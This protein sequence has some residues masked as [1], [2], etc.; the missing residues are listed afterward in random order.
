MIDMSPAF[1]SGFCTDITVRRYELIAESHGRYNYEAKE[2]KMRAS[3]QPAGPEILER[4]EATAQGRMFKAVTIFSLQALQIG[5]RPDTVL[6]NGDEYGITD[7]E[8][9]LASNA[10]KATAVRFLN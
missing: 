10:F 3:V 2:F 4:I 8:I 5:E 7:C 6:I 1:F 9:Y